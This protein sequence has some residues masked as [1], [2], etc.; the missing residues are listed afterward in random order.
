MKARNEYYH[1]KQLKENVYRIT[2]D[3]AVFCDLFVGTEKAL[4]LDTGYGFG[5]RL[6]LRGL[7]RNHYKLSNC[8]FPW[9]C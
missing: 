9:S 1:V 6:S 5:E 4:L 2:S 8:Q 7:P 3:E